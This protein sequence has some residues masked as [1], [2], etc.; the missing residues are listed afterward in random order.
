MAT[1][2]KGMQGGHEDAYNFYLSQIRIT[3]ERAFGVLVHWW[4]ILRAPLLCPMS[5][6]GPLIES[7]VRLHIFCIDQNR[8]LESL[9]V[10][11][12]N[13]ASLVNSVNLSKLFGS[14]SDAE[15]NNFDD[16]GCPVLLL[17]CCHHF[18]NAGRNRRPESS[19][20]PMDDMMQRVKDLGLSCPK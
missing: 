17:G 5:K 2:L 15:Y 3:I 1:P 14:G 7:L 9:D 11:I 16:L 4:A 6:V 19:R 12:K 13:R 8:E 10:Q 18:N 20:T